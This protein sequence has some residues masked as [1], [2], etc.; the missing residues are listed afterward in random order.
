MRIDRVPEFYGCWESF[1]ECFGTYIKSL[2]IYGITEVSLGPDKASGLEILS[3]FLL[4]VLLNL[5][6]LH[7]VFRDKRFNGRS[8]SRSDAGTNLLPAV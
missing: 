7:L 4:S 5:E 6:E 1:L 3:K 2:H 8:E